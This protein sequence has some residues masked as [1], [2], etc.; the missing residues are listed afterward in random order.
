MELS[1]ISPALNIKTQKGRPECLPFPVVREPVFIV[2]VKRERG[3][4][5]W[6]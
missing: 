3:E 4:T 5:A 1:W 6:G 2:A